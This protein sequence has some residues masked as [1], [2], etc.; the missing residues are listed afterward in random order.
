V[1]SATPSHLTIMQEMNAAGGVRRLRL[2]QDRDSTGVEPD[3]VPVSYTF[4]IRKL[5]SIRALK[6]PVVLSMSFFS[7]LLLCHP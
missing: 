4:A 7:P 5:N 2:R 3:P 6:Y 1:A